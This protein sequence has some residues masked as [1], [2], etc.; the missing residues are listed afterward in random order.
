VT[1]TGPELQADGQSVAMESLELAHDGL[2]T[3]SGLP[4]GRE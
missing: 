1:W 4:E 2:S 3:V